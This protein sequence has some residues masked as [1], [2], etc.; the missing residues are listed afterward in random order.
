[1]LQIGSPDSNLR[2]GRLATQLKA[3]EEYVSQLASFEAAGH[4]DLT[5]THRYMHLTPGVVDSAI[6]LLETT[7]MLASRGKHCDNGRDRDRE[8]VCV[9]EVNWR[10]ERDSN[11]R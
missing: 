9:E 7:S 1:V 5:T 3:C 2:H 6:R 11:P 10:R 8:L 4:A